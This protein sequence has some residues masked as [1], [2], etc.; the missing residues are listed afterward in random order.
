LPTTRIDRFGASRHGLISLGASRREHRNAHRLAGTSGQHGRTAHLLVGLLG[1]HAKAYGHVDRFD[2]LCLASVF[3]D[4][5]CFFDR[6]RFAR[7]GGG[8]D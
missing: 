6:V 8:E 3:Q 5:Q 1:I 2:E 7:L 4:L